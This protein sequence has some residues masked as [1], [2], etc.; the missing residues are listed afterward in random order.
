MTETT[1]NDVPRK[2]LDPSDDY[3]DPTPCPECGVGDAEYGVH[4][5]GCPSGYPTL[6]DT[7]RMEA[8]EVLMEKRAE[9]AHAPDMDTDAFAFEGE[10]TEDEEWAHDSNWHPVLGP[11]AR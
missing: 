2:S 9:A 6:D 4:E 11:G 1:W 7:D 3:T 5:R 10:W 8:G